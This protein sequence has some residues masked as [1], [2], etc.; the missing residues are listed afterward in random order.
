MA[1]RVGKRGQEIYAIY[2]FH[3]LSYHL[4]ADVFYKNINSVAKSVL[5]RGSQDIF[6]NAWS[7][8][9]FG[10]SESPDQLNVQ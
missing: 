1:G 7:P 10:I 2:L 5:E 8:T 4:Q 6:H 3:F 9:A